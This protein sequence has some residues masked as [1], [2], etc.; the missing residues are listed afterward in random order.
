[1]TDQGEKMKKTIETALGSITGLEFENHLEF[2]GIRYAE[3]DR[4]E[5][6]KITGK[7][8]RT[9]DATEFG[10]CS[11][12]RRAF[13]KD[14]ECNPFYHKEFRVGQEFEYSEDCQFLNIYT[15]KDKTN[16]P[17]LIY[18]HGGSFTGGSS[19]ENHISGERYA[20][21]GIVFVSINYRLNAFGF[22]AHS[23]LVK[24]GYAGN[25]GLFDQE[26]AI[27]WVRDY[28]SDFGGDPKKITLLGQSAGAMSVDILISDP[29]LE[30]LI[31]GAIM[32][33][34]AGLQR[35]GAR[36]MEIKSLDTFWDCIR[37]TAC[38][39]SFEELKKVDPETLFYSWSSACKLDKLSMLKTM[40]V[41][42]GRIITK[43]GFTR[44][45]IPG[46]PILL[47]ITA[48]DMMPFILEGLIRQYS[49][50]A[51]KNGSHCY[52]YSFERMLPGDRS[53][54]W[55]SSDLL[56][57]FGTLSKNWRPFEEVDHKISEAMI[58]A[59][60]EFCRTS[61]PNCNE[62]PNWACGVKNAMHFGN[63]FTTGDI[64]RKAY[65]KSMFSKGGA[66]F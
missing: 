44:K 7:W 21:N 37:E 20:Q 10:A 17:V 2:R 29:R 12:Q 40:P 9:I 30:G 24:D 59:I 64:S 32:M 36:P 62:L 41:H 28:I 11:F 27:F 39:G 50:E 15:P 4:W 45:S 51:A 19:N 8:D 26:C 5:Y 23:G 31:S 25:Y 54:A 48:T 63:S 58:S 53:G 57:A 55:H 33:S 35:F 60:T 52:V 22:C 3:A 14:E 6:P 13:E 56:Y 49:A 46:I 34:G 66:E 1:M 65:L 47:G 61:N 38:V 18:I 43:T 16:C 42:D